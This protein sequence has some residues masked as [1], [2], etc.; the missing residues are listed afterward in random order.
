MWRGGRG[1]RGE[2]GGGTVGG[3][4]GGRAGGEFRLARGKP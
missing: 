4:G 1:V 3:G 2:G